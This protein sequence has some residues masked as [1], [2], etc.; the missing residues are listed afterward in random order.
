MTFGQRVRELRQAKGMTLRALAP[1]V[2]VGF[3]YLSK[4]ETGSLDFGDFPSEALIRKGPL[5]AL[6]VARIIRQAARALAKAHS[7]GIV[8]RDLK[9]DNVILT[10]RAGQ[11]DYVKLL[12]FGIAKRRNDSQINE[13]QL[14]QQGTVLGTPPYMSPEQFTG[15]PVT[16]RSDIYS[17]GIMT[18]EMLTGKIAFEGDTVGQILMKILNHTPT[19]PSQ[20]QPGIA[21]AHRKSRL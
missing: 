10:K 17:L 1:R 18:Y 13:K 9:P 14:T 7:A 19:P 8:H 11:T 3:T 21:A 6:E 20:V 12:D 16:A 4:V 5:P 15:Q 2:G